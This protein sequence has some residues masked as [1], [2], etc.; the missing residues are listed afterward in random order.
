MSQKPDESQNEDKVQQVQ[1]QKK[2]HKAL[3][4]L[5]LAEIMEEQKESSRQSERTVNPGVPRQSN[6]TLVMKRPKTL[7]NKRNNKFTRYN[8]SVLPKQPKVMAAAGN[9]YAVQ[10]EVNGGDIFMTPRSNE[11]KEVS[12]IR[13]IDRDNQ[14][15][16]KKRTL[17]RHDSSIER[18]YQ[19]MV[20]DDIVSTPDQNNQQKAQNFN[21]DDYILE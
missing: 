1:P 18:D 16:E 11:S 2:K 15:I 17:F 4:T 5:E 9:S 19:D 21:A 6:A 13:V 7:D 10:N 3:R 12:P 14:V 20:K 8:D